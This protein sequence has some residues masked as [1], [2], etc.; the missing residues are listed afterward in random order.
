M[1]VPEPE[2]RSVPSGKT[3]GTFIHDTAHAAPTFPGETREGA[4]EE[5]VHA[6]C[7]LIGEAGILIQGASGAGKSTLARELV[8]AARQNGL[9]A[10]LVADDRV[11][12]T[13]RH[14]R[15]LA[16]TV[17]AIA[18]KIEMRGLGILD[19]AHERMAVLR[20]VIRL[21]S[22]GPPRMPDVSD[23][24]MTLCGIVLPRL[25]LQSRVA[26]APLVLARLQQ[27]VNALVTL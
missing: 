3:S 12:L 24:T 15:L 2:T 13:V 11:R 20:L 4:I 21:S 26:S 18:G 8:A 22:H 16:H 5:T 27:Q 25:L 23:E 6:S 17:D 10:R 7:V 9:F 1:Q 19:T 14:G